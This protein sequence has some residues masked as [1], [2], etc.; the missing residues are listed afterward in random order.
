MSFVL[1][2]PKALERRVETEA[3]KA[4]ISPPEYLIALIQ[5]RFRENDLDPT[6]ALFAQWEQEDT[7]IAPEQL[8]ENE[9]I[10]AEIEKTGISRTQL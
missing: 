8:A 2:L 1:D 10:Y 9:R 6:L 7:K 3:Q 4:G 5:S